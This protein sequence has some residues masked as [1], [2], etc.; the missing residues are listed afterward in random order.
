MVDSSF[1]QRTFCFSGGG[2]FGDEL[3]A[4]WATDAATS[5]STMLRAC[6]NLSPEVLLGVTTYSIEARHLASAIYFGLAQLFDRGLGGD[7]RIVNLL[8][9]VR[10]GFG[11][12]DRHDLNVP[13]VVVVN[14]LPIAEGFRG[15]QAVGRGMQH[16]VK[17]LCDGAN[18]LQG[19]AQKCREIHAQSRLRQSRALEGGV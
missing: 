10:A 9:S 13:V 2:T 11:G 14:S 6:F 8:E 3:L 15:M 7:R 17:T 4:V 18:A 19:A 5:N 12:E 16:E 1:C